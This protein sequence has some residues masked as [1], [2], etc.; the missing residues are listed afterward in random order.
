M[1]RARGAE[2]LGVGGDVTL[3]LG[4]PHVRVAQLDL[5][6]APLVGRGAAQPA[7]PPRGV[8]LRETRA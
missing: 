6:F 4:Q 5:E 2:H 1:L 8:P 3:R 7:E